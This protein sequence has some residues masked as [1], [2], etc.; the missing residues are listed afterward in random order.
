MALFNEPRAA[1]MLRQL[2]SVLVQAVARPE[3]PVGSLSLVTAEAAALLPD[4]AAVLGDQWYGP[5]HELFRERAALHPERPAVV[6]QDET[7]SY[8]ELAE[9]SRRIAARLQAGGARRGDRIAIY[10]YRS[11]ALVAAVMGVLE[12][13]AAFVILDPA[14]PAPRL[15]DVA[16]IAEARILIRL[17]AAGAL[18]E[19][20]S[21]L[22]EIA[23]PVGG[24]AAVTAAIPEGEPV[25][26]ALGPDD[27]AYVAFT[28]GSTGVPK[29]ILGPHGG[30]SH[31]LPWMRDRFGLS[32]GDRF[33]LLSGLSHD[34]L[35]R[36]IFT[37]LFLGATICVPDPDDVA[38]SRLAGW[39]AR[40]G[41]TFSNLTPAMAQV[42]TEGV[43][44]GFSLPEL[45]CA[46]LVGDVLTRLDLARLR[47]LAP[48]VTCVNLYGATET[49]RALSYHVAGE[50][51]I[52][53]GERG[54]QVLPL[55]RGM[56]DCQLLVLSRDG[57]L[58]GVGELGEICIRSPHLA[59]G[60]LDDPELTRERFL[61][62]PFRAGDRIYRTGDLGRYLPDGEVELIG[63]ADFQV[64][65]RGFR[66]ELGEIEAH[67]GRQPG[68]KEAVVVASEA[69]GLG[70]VLVAYVVPEPE[71]PEEE[72][73]AEA[74]RESLKALLPGYMI[75]AAVVLREA[76]PVTPNGK[77][78]RKSL[79]ALGVPRGSVEAPA[80]EARTPVEE[81]LAGIWR[82]VLGLE[83]VG[84]RQDF[85]D[86]GGHSLL[87]TQIVSRVRDVFGVEIPLRALFES[88][89]VV[90]LARRIESARPEGPGSA[91]LRPMPREGAL[92]PSFAQERLWFLDRL[93]GGGPAYNVFTAVRLSGRLDLARLRAAFAGLVRR[94]E[95]LRT[96]FAE[97]GGSPVQVIAPAL[98]VDLPVTDLTALPPDMREAAVRERANAEARWVFDLA[99]GPLMR[100]S[101]L[102]LGDEEHA[103]LLNLHHIVSDA[104]SRGVLIRDVAALYEGSGLP[105]LP[106]QYADYS[107]WQRG[108]LRGEALER[109][110]AWWREK[111]AGAPEVLDL[112][113]DRPRPLRRSQRGGVVEA[114]VSP[115]VAAGLRA[116]GRR[117]G[118]TPF[119]TL[120]AAFQALL[121]RYTGGEDAPVGSPIAGRTRSELEGLIGFFVNT[122]VLRTGLAGD[123]AFAELLARARETTLGAYAHQDLPFEKL[124]EELAPRRDLSHSPLFQVMLVLQNAPQRPIELPGLR[125]Q[126]LEAE[127]GTAKFDLSLV[128]REAGEGLAAWLEYDLDL[129]DPA[130][131]ERIAGH[132]R[133]L[134]EGAAADPG[135]RLSEL[136]LLTAAEAG[137]IAAWSLGA[138]TVAEARRVH[139]LFEAWADRT[140]DAVAV[141]AGGE[142]L[143]YG[144]LEAGAN[145]LARR[146][147][148]LG[149]GPEVPVGLSMPRSPEGVAALLAIFKAGGVYLPIDPSYP[150]ERRLWMLVD[151]GVRVLVTTEA[152]REDLPVPE[153][154]EVLCVDEPGIG[155]EDASRETGPALPE[156]LAYVVY[157]SGSTGLPKGVGVAHA[158]AARH[159]RDAVAAFGLGP[160]DRTLQT[161]SW[162]FD[163]SLDQ[164]LWPLTAG[165][166]LAIWEGDID[167]AD[168]QDR[169]LGLGI[170]ILDMAPAVLHLWTRRTAGAGEPDLPVRA[171]LVG[172][173]TLPPEVV[174]LWPQT[175]L[176]NARLLNGYG[177]TEA[178]ITATWQEAPSGASLPSVPIGSPLPGRTAH[179]LDAGGQPVP[180]GVPGELALGGVL[181]RGYLG[182]PDVTAERFVPDPFADHP[183]A[184]L[185]RTGD[186]VRWLPT[187]GLEFL[188]RVDQQIKIR[189][190][191]IEPGEIEAALAS[192]PAV[193]QAAVVAVG[194]E[195]LRLVAFLVP[196]EGAEEPVPGPGELRIFLSRTLPAHM[197]PAVF[198]EI[199][200]LPLT[201]SAKVDR[202]ALARRA[203]AP[204][205]QRAFVAPA[206]PV[207]EI[208]AGIWAAV[209]RAEWVGAQD[210]FFDLGGHSLLA[211][212]VVSRIREALG[213]ELPLRVLF[214]SPTLR[215]VAGAV[216]AVRAAGQ[217]EAAPPLVRVPREGALPVS[218]G[219]RRLWFLDRLEPGSPAYNVSAA[220]RLTGSLDATALART[221]DE[222]VRRHEVLRTTFGEEGSEPVQVIHAPRP[223][224]LEVRDLSGL[225][226]DRREAEARR[227]V[228]A[229]QRR[230]FDLAA[231]PLL[232]ASLLRLESEEHVLLFAVHHVAS[233]GW[234]MGVLV[235]E[236]GTL[237]RAF[238]AGEPSPLPEPPVQYADYAAWQRSW[239]RGEVLQQHVAWWRERLAGAPVLLP[240]PTDRQRPA[241]QRFH[242]A[243]RSAWLPAEASAALRSLG[244]ERG[245]TLFMTVLA[246]F[247][248]LLQRHSGED[249]LVV[250]TPTANRDRP[251]LEGLIGFFVNSLALRI[252]LAGD[253]SFPELLGR[254]REMLLGAYA[255]QDLPFE[256]LVEELQPERSLAHSPLFQV[257]LV[258]QG[259]EAAGSVLELPGLTLRPEA[260]PHEISKFDLTLTVDDTPA[261]LFCQWRYNVELFD[262]ATI[263]RMAERFRILVEGIA[264]QPD[265]PL[266]GL[267]LLEDAERQ[268]L[269]REWSRGEAAVPGARLLHEMVEEQADRRPEAVA[270]VF[271][272]GELTYG[273]LDRRANRLARRLR[274]MGVGP[275]VP[276]GLAA[277]R[278]P[279]TVIGLLAI[280]KAGGAYVPIDP[281]YPAERAAW[282]RADSGI[283]VLLTQQ[284][285]LAEPEESSERLAPLAG[286]DNLAYVIYT[287]GSTG[288]PKGVLVTH[289]GLDNLAEAQG[290]LF[291]IEP[292][293][294]VLQ[295]ASMS[296]DA[297]VSEIA[298]AFRAGATLVMAGRRSLLPGPE[299]IELLRRPGDHQGDAAAHGP[300]GA[301]GGGPAGAADDRGG[302]RGLPA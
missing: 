181:A 163:A 146:L 43:E 124:V 274:R 116:A 263:D 192:H 140:P 161:A 164:L 253:P 177:P 127:T 104:W 6:G 45:R 185:Y 83:Q 13:G 96:R 201:A 198:V 112:P 119:M 244:R 286:P 144:E 273:E 59:L 145:R 70:K 241:V 51:E 232:R 122:L 154:V 138:E 87:A 262:A 278:S 27:L 56:E 90:S 285:L 28:S 86:L 194:E 260:R 173:D 89:T 47:R 66:I 38:P 248:V 175:P 235:Q 128:A 259:Q 32:A 57:L 200:A 111:L 249:D 36:D 29:G 302:G 205:A 131:A 231:G 172:G 92:P 178:V 64:K 65:I 293:S 210:G 252:G 202:R 236:V 97:M 137:Q 234:S 170:T 189:G 225:P 220:L 256:K 261:G 187:G 126:P 247:A 31:F 292:D 240:L 8:G 4:P 73:S 265:R 82:D 151:A 167:P 84:V 21:A 74:L 223:L 208:L 238:V 22:P 147:R 165:A 266:S 78:D 153:G 272:E 37:A 120:L 206:T 162:S 62:N 15:L 229:D 226:A 5:V 60:Y 35:Q 103:L 25:P 79:S 227:L 169:V 1:E 100:L 125:L 113:A 191:R 42:L 26:V 291:G 258:L 193:A 91:P 34:P 33:T 294:R 133:T 197:L 215:D 246:A 17:E 81:L 216:E 55:G 20:L 283:S 41:V 3:A 18:P 30:L 9:A 77:V 188:G 233:D 14:Y 10:A 98:D 63:R 75:P 267:P 114:P 40:E 299:L 71:A 204:E 254:V 58:A 217:G 183:G 135:R 300:G 160:R 199:P 282:M 230:P 143:T 54:R 68:V 109:Q 203:P 277:E 255:H 284:E 264:A 270:V 180:A 245:A 118:A 222:I 108:W 295:F 150:R 115:E 301:A 12:A 288:T 228:L 39:M 99:A 296:F 148:R 130:T 182:R 117:A 88:P 171:V 53:E 123:P 48:A 224:G 214:E 16:R 297:S 218:F 94:H 281:A 52:A 269:L 106:V 102:R 158:M 132:F 121:W 61:P 298:M 2:E 80:D 174:R 19:E 276:V 72:V 129:F 207:E 7:W 237:Y 67:L 156:S 268:Q 250:G 155:L 176:R 141:V 280:L 159:L 24:P 290:R 149:V 279:E 46:M 190:F 152:L 271:E 157:T 76:L 23:L 142:A 49:Q 242:G 85:F 287:S 289:R 105:E 50:S 211:V 134:L 212:Q 93:E 209:L 136:P 95:S 275:E 166:S 221:L 251:E 44:E 219:Q 243:R 168:L 213:V 110:L 101:L 139:E 69:P 196:R 195:D 186:K 179:V 11:P 257:M 107:L 184:R 239:L